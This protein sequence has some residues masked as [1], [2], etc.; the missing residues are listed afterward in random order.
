[1]VAKSMEFRRQIA[2][3]LRGQARA[4]LFTLPNQCTR[5]QSPVCSRVSVSTARRSYAT[6]SRPR[7]AVGETSQPARKRTTTSATKKTAKS[8]AKPKA[9]KPKVAKKA[10][11]KP[12]T[13]AKPPTERQLQLR[14]ARKEKEELQRL[15]VAA[16]L[17][18]PRLRGKQGPYNAFMAEKNSSGTFDAAQVKSIAANYQSLSS[19]EKQV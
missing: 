8:A 11:K 12:K 19:L 15:K 10:A 6:P 17:D 2:S 4:R 14:A 18:A 7:K 16:L 3:L 5:R 1:M 13:A 9:K